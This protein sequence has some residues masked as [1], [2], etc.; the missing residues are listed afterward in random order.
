M[1]ILVI[2]GTRYMGRIAVQR[3]LDQG[4]E[5]A[6][7]SRGNIQPEWWD[8]IEH[9]AGDR[10]DSADFNAKLRGRE[11]DGVL[12]MRAFRKEHVESA[13]DLFRDRVDRYLMVS[14]GSVYF[15]GKLDFASVCPYRE[16]DVSWSD[17]DYSYPE[18]EDPYG[19]G[20][21]HCEK[22]LQENSPVPYTIVRIPA[23]MGWDDPTGRMWWWVLRAL[24]GGGIVIPEQHRAVFRTLYSEDAAENFV[25]ALKAPEAAGQT[26]HIAMREIMT[27]ERWTQLIWDA[28]GSQCEITY[29]P[30]EVIQRQLSD[31]EPHL[32][33]ALPYIQD[34]SKAEREFGFA[35]TPVAEW[36]QTTVDW[37]R[38]E[39]RGEDSQTYGYRS[40]ELDLAAAWRRA[41]G[42]L[43]SS[44]D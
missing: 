13:C 36:V 33:R 25:R 44:F 23:V 6:V 17:I 3:P 29:V 8:R 4:D 15:D 5:V 31:Y 39:Y 20:K 9:I 35:T 12:D 42:D 24:D 30:Q 16:T 7:L 14:T 28:T 18:G 2:G 26:Y 37:Y 19:V 32:S 1:K 11:F 40:A 38:R 43:I 27:M 10:T 41:F 21:R 34:T 22:W